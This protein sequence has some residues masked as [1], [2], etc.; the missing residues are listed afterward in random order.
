VS[1]KKSDSPVVSI[2]VLSWNTRELT[3]ACLES[4]ENVAIAHEVLVLDNASEDGSADA[5]AD[6]FPDVEL[7]RESHNQGYAIGNNRLAAKASGRYLCLLNSDTEVPAGAL[8]RLA[9]F[10]DSEPEYAAVAPELVGPDGVIQHSCKRFPGLGVALVY[11]MPWRGW[12]LL[13]RIDDRYFYRD[14][15]HASDRDVD[16]PPGACFMIRRNLW[17]ELGGFDESLW[18]FY[19]DVDLC[20]RLRRTGARIRY[21][22]DVAILHHEGASTT[23]FSDM[24]QVWARNRLAYYGKHHGRFGRR[25]VRVMLRLRG[26]HE[27]WCLGR[28]HQDPKHRKDARA[29]LRRVM[30][31]V[32][33]R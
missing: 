25:L 29:E 17:E 24:V 8:E 21:L 31:E 33:A 20:L 16:Q 23:R 12:P 1:D 26:W 30:R 27:W 9:A 10:L 6:R 11:D 3:L 18:L 4:L 13:K 14:F 22:A 15:D 2:L 32:L 5:I 19:N 7:V 28:R